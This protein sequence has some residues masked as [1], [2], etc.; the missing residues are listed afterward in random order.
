MKKSFLYL[1]LPAFFLFSCAGS[2][3]DP[4][5][6]MKQYMSALSEFDFAR[7]N[8]LVTDNYKSYIKVYEDDE[9]LLSPADR[10][11]EIKRMSR[12]KI[13]YV[14]GAKSESTAVVAV[15]IDF[16]GVQKVMTI[17]YYLKNHNNKWLIDSHERE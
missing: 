10:K 11:A 16:E 1:L 8:K 14:P 4:V 7:A 5:D 2:A 6:T 9:K 3:D 15:T 13:I 12:Q 17:K